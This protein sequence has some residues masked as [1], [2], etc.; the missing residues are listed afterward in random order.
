[1]NT[2]R[3]TGAATLRVDLPHAMLTLQDATPEAVGSSFLASLGW[4]DITALGIVLV[5]F[6]LGLFHGLIWQVSRIIT[7]ILAYLISGAYGGLVASKI[8]PW[9]NADLSAD[10]PRYAAYAVVFVAVVIV[11]SLIAYFIEK[12][13]ERAGLSF[14]NRIFGGV[15]GVITGGCIVLALLAGLQM[16]FGPNSSIVQAARNSHSMSMSKSTLALLGEKVPVDIRK[17]F[18]MAPETSAEP[19]PAAP[20]NGR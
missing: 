17:A 6:V 4:I 2:G 12:L 10:I 7:L 19:T 9:F 1:M 15:L 13:I 5:F 3:I 8:Q 18:G 14:Y 16:F 11:V 20:E